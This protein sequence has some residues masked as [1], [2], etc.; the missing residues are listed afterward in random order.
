MYAPGV[1]LPK[2]A[3]WLLCVALLLWAVAMFAVVNVSLAFASASG[4][5]GLSDPHNSQVQHAGEVDNQSTEYAIGGEGV[6]AAQDSPTPDDSGTEVPFDGQEDGGDLP[7]DPPETPPPDAEI[8]L[9]E[10]PGN[11]EDAL[12]SVPATQITPEPQDKDPPEPQPPET[13]PSDTEPSET[14]APEP[15]PTPAEGAESGLPP[16][17]DLDSEEEPEPEEAQQ[18]QET[19]QPPELT[20]PPT[21]DPTPK[22]R[23]QVSSPPTSPGS[24]RPLGL[25]GY[26]APLGGL[27]GDDYPLK[28]KMFPLYPIIW[29]EWNFAH[30]QCTSFVAWRLQQVNKVPFANSSLGVA[31]W[32]NAG[33]WGDAARSA[34]FVVDR[35]PAVGAVAFNA[36]FHNGTGAAGHVAWVAAVLDDDRIIVEEYNYTMPGG[37]YLARAVP[38]AAFSGFIHIRDLA[39]SPA[40]RDVP[41][42]AVTTALATA[43]SVN[44]SLS[45]TELKPAAQF[46]FE[47]SLVAIRARQVFRFEYLI[48]R[49]NAENEGTDMG[50]KPFIG[51]IA[52]LCMVVTLAG[53]ADDLPSNSVNNLEELRAAYVATG[54]PCE[55]WQAGSAPGIWNEFGNCDVTGGGLLKVWLSPR[56]HSSLEAVLEG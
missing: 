46:S 21:P 40:G 30:R 26:P 27:I 53:C 5:D 25:Q 49:L 56:P 1:T 20:T 35:T 2:I 52:S 29:D 14:A 44:N 3:T 45:D 47:A 37:R 12:E 39:P 32:G 22:S 7:V 28:Y 31:R 17:G 42:S 11:A 18:P 13:E 23:T 33:Q 50:V 38:K 36:P 24:A 8:T 51:S 48:G 10:Q 19:Q 34:G 15:D 4:V 16:E 6:T 55:I 9:D 41:V 54:A 43:T